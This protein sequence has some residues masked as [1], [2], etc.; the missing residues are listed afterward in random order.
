VIYHF[1]LAAVA[2][3]TGFLYL[4]LH[5]WAA[6]QP[7]RFI[8]LAKT[9]PRHLIIGRVLMAVAAV[10]MVWMCA[11]MDL[12]EFTA[13]RTPITIFF[14]ALGVGAFWLLSDYLAVRALAALL[15]LGANV[16]LDAAFMSDNPWK[17]VIPLLAY[18]WII[19]GIIL[20]C[21]PYRLRDGLD[22]ALKDEKRCQLFAWPGVV[23][24]VILVGLGL[25]VY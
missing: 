25:F 15:L 9:F 18:L 20:V 8:P 12:G 21:S 2:I 6:L 16:L 4:V 3:V 7:G 19:V 5:L 13:M 1:S 22:W 24:G 11:T 14:G 10:W 23:F 17:L